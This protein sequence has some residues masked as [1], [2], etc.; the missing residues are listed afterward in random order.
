MT[1]SA[2]VADGACITFGF[3]SYHLDGHF[4]YIFFLV[5]WSADSVVMQAGSGACG[6]QGQ[7]LLGEAPRDQCSGDHFD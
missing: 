7:P 5:L 2:H 3:S 1:W 6:V 4:F